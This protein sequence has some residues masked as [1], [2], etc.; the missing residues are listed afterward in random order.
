MALK[1]DYVKLRQLFEDF[2][3]LTGI[4]ISLFDDNYNEILSYPEGH[5]SLCLYL[6][7]NAG[8]AERCSCSDAYSFERCKKERRLIIYNCHAGLTEV[9]VPLIEDELIIGFIMFGQITV[10]KNRNAFIENICN[11]CKN[12]NVDINI[13]KEKAK[14]IKYKTKKEI[15]AASEIF[16]ACTKYILLEELITSK[17]NDLFNRMNSYIDEHLGEKIDISML[18]K[19]LGLSRTKLYELSKK[20]I[21][22]GIANYIKEKRLNKA[23]EMLN[24]T[25]LSITQISNQVGFNDYNYF[26]KSFKKYFGISPKKYRSKKYTN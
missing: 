14:K 23:K 15:Q 11:A 18:C 22:N 7:E 25:D 16:D 5:S 17:K 4:K 6:R 24:N 2:H 10:Q 21:S 20:Y 1:F 9:T 12:Y 26:L 19:K 8:V 13:A 3:I